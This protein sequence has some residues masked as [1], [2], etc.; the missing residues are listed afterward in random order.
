MRLTVFSAPKCLGCH[1]MMEYLDSRGL[2][3]EKQDILAN[4]GAKGFVQ[5]RTGGRLTV[6][7]LWEGDSATSLVGFSN[8][9]VDEF[10][11]GLT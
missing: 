4:G 8:E 10:L 5:N 7:M 6:P 1:Q 3:Y 2:E 11:E 9:R